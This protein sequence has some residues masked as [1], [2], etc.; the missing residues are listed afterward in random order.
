VASLVLGGVSDEA[1][2]LESPHALVICA[3]CVTDADTAIEDSVRGALRQM[4]RFEVLPAPAL[5]LEAVQLSIDCP[6]PSARCLRAVAKKLDAGVLLVPAIVRKR[7]QIELRLLYFDAASGGE[8]RSVTRGRTMTKAGRG[9]GEWDAELPGML[10]E[11]IGEASEDRYEA[12]PP[13]AATPTTPEATG[14]DEAGSRLAAGARTSGEASGDSALPLGPLVLGAGGLAV[15][16]AGLVTGAIMRGT[17]DDYAERTVDN[18]E[19]ARLA[20][21]ARTRGRTQALVANVL[22]GTGAAAVAAAGIWLALDLRAQERPAQASLRP[23]LGPDQAGV[24][25]I[26]RWGQSP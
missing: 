22:L 24:Q 23:I 2:A 13:S 16:A 25:W 21:Q 8:P 6:E 10:R 11:L 20:E 12:E 3:Q 18:Q 1:S 14:T 15:V 5:D 4:Q 26:A 7:A 19:Q 9:S 17:E